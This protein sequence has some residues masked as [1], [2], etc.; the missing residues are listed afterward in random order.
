MLQNQFINFFVT[1]SNMYGL[2]PIYYASNNIYR[3]WISGIV[4]SSSLMHISET[5]HGLPGVYPFNKYS[6]QFLWLDRFMAYTPM[7]YVGYLMLY[8][9]EFMLLMMLLNKYMIIGTTCLLISERVGTKHKYLFAILHSIWHICAYH[10][11]SLFFTYYK[12]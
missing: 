2:V 6:K 8:K 1:S 11:I 12:R 10:T 4:L 7:M 3:T 5:K 9:K